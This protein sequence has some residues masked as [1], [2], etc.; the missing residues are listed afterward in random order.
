MIER[1]EYQL[2]FHESILSSIGGDVLR[3]VVCSLQECGTVY[4]GR[5]E[6]S[7]ERKMKVEN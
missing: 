7:Q 4:H 5:K 1:S 2:I 3:M 6:I